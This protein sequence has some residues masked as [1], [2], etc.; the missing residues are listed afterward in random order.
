MAGSPCPEEVMRRVIE[1]MNMSKVTVKDYKVQPKLQ[2]SFI[3]RIKVQS[4]A[5]KY[6][7]CTQICYGTTENSPVTFQTYQ[8]DSL[9]RRVSTI[10]TPHPHIEV[11]TLHT[12][13]IVLL[14]ILL[15]N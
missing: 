14:F 11:N 3:R 5:V 2:P 9:D 13:S 1:E 7:Y 8:T 10:G 4:D 15:L 12:V 6:M